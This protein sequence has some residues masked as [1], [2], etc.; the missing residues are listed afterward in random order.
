M[1]DY[2]VYKD[3]SDVLLIGHIGKLIKVAQGIMNTHS[4]YADGRTTLLSLEAVFAGASRELA[5]EIYDSLTTD[6]AVRI[7]SEAKL[8]TP[9][10]DAVCQ[11]IDHYL[12]ARTTVP[13]V[14]GP[15][16][17]P[18]FTAS[19]G[20]HHRPKTYWPSIRK[21]KFD[22]TF[23]RCGPGA[24][25]LITVRGKTLLEQADQIIYAGSLVNQELLTYAKKDC[26][27]LDSAAM[28]L[29]DVMAAMETAEKL[30]WMTVRLH[31]G[32]PVGLRG[33]SR[34][35]WN[36]LAEKTSPST[37][38]PASV[39]SAAPR[40]PEG[41]IHLARHQPVGHHYPHGRAD[42]RPR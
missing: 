13:S 33:H 28:T 29:E 11:K 1:L 17:S 8:L 14:P 4:R 3:F 34:T 16:Y 25:D 24:V 21:G 20:I 26:V 31:T 42:P 15:S 9:V 36:I 18:T 12:E 41:R 37:S 32:D 6:E 22:D 27:I 23:C 30:G 38:F 35:R 40:R 7:L 2:A 39:R 10:M 19:S 5:R